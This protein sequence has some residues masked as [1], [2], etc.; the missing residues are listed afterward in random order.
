MDEIE[1]GSFF[2]GLTIASETMSDVEGDIQKVN[3]QP[4]STDLPNQVD[5]RKKGYVNR[6]QNQ[7]RCGSCYAFSAVAAIEGQYFKATGEL[8]KLS[9][10]NLLKKR[11]RLATIF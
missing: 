5:W 2:K 8:L 9:G 10:W 4:Q 7:K 11:I 1:F 6:I 3:Y